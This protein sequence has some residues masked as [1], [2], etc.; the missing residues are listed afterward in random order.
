MP[1]SIAVNGNAS[2]NGSLYNNVDTKGN[3]TSMVRNGDHNQ[4][5]AA[6]SLLMAGH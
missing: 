6:Q 1:L 3:I 2:V 5:N 4:A